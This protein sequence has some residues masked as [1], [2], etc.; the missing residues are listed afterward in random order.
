[1]PSPEKTMPLSY[2]LSPGSKIMH[3]ATH[4]HVLQATN[5]ICSA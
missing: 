1:L 4:D 5:N 3:R 2:F